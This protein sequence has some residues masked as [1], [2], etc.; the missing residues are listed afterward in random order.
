[1]VEVEETFSE[2]SNFIYLSKVALPNATCPTKVDSASPRHWPGLT[3]IRHFR[4]TDICPSFLILV[5]RC[6]MICT[7]SGARCVCN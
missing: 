3:S 7:G 5:P 6:S 4:Q 1:V 2:K